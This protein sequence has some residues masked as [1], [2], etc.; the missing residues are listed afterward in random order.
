[1]SGGTMR[2]AAGLFERDGAGEKNLVFD[3]D[4]L[5]KIQFHDGEPA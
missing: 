1:V 2:A 5:A 3:A 4:V